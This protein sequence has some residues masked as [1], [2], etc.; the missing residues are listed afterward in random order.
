MLA[1]A[2][3]YNSSLRFLFH[4]F[5]SLLITRDEAATRS[6][7]GFPLRELSLGT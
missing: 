5:R 6:R 3:Y 2:P 1:A 4:L 7:Q